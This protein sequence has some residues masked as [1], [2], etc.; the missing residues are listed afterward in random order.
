MKCVKNQIIAMCAALICLIPSVAQD[1]PSET[2]PSVQNNAAQ[3]PVQEKAPAVNT[4]K[5]DALLLYQ[6]GDYADAIA[7]C[8]AEIATDPT[9]LESYVVMCW[10]LLKNKQYAEAEQQATA[11]LNISPYD[12]RLIEILGEAKYYLGKNNGALEQF[13]KYV[14]SAPESAARAGAA[15][16]FMGEIYIRQARYQHADISLSAAVKK[17]PLLDHWWT[18]LGYA[19]EMAGNY[20]EAASAYDEALRLNPTSEDAQNGR[21][22][23]TAKL[24]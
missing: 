2:L 4:V 5:K 22:R 7:I 11:G 3:V 16:Y 24:Q 20:Y 14:A 9:R 21:K 10:S 8:E 6:N 1:A 12:L 15:Y 13:Q 23:V 18:R 17:E 19:R